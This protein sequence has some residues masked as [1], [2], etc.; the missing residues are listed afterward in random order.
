MQFGVNKHKWI[1]QRQQNYMSLYDM[2][3]YFHQFAQ[4]IILLLMNNLHE[5]NFTENKDKQNFDSVCYL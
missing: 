4:D 3:N 1:F 5:K 2:W